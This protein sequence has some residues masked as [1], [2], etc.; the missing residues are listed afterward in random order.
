MLQD[1]LSAV[2]KRTIIYEAKAR[3]AGNTIA[4]LKQGAQ[5]NS[6]LALLVQKYKY[7]SCQGASSWQYDSGPQARCSVSVSLLY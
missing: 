5:F 4:V 6:L 1:E 2:D 3:R 7:G